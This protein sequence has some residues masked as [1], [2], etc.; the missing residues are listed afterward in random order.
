MREIENRKDCVQCRENNSGFCKQTLTK[1]RMQITRLKRREQ[2]RYLPPT[3]D[4]NFQTRQN[5]PLDF[6]FEPG[7]SELGSAPRQAQDTCTRSSSA[8][9]FERNTQTPSLQYRLPQVW[10]NVVMRGETLVSKQPR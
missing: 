10:L 8:K 9:I 1:W 3:G 6:T 5:I 4:F 2:G 7:E